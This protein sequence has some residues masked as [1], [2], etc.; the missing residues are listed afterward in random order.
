[1]H[2][3]VD[4]APDRIRASHSATHQSPAL[5]NRLGA[6]VTQKG[7]LV[8][9][10]FQ[11]DFSHPKALTPEEIAQIEADVNAQIRA[12]EPVSTRLM[13][14]RARS[15][16][17]DGAVR[18][19]G[20]EVR[21]LSMGKGDEHGYSVELCGGARARAGRH[22][23]VQDHQRK[24]GFVGRPAYQGA[25]TEERETPPSVA[26]GPRRGAEVGRGGA[27]GPRRPEVPA[28]VAAMAK[29]LKAK[30]R[31]GR[32]E[33]ALALG[34]GGAGNPE[35]ALIPAIE[36]VGDVAFLA[37]VVEGSIPRNFAA[38]SMASKQVGGGTM[39]VLDADQ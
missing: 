8:A 18:R 25:L 19:N 15:Q 33:E 34:G 10:D 23:L 5:R 21:V 13:T 28:R 35:P 31:A 32:R 16:R 22:R 24:R 20:D 11:F 29:A 7:S 30:T 3:S 27:Q 9:D 26:A 2:L 6:H 39:R 12:N 17:G 4:A 1:M 38:R 37:Q 14:P 36:H